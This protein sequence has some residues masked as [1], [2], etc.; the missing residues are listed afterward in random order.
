[1]QK[2]LPLRP[3]A[4]VLRLLPALLLLLSLPAVLSSQEKG[5]QK[6]ERQDY[7]KKWLAEDVTL[8]ISPE[9]RSVFEHLSEPEEKERFIEQFWLRRDTNPGTTH[10]EFKEEHYRRIAFANERFR[11]G[12]F[13]GWKTDRGRAYIRFGP[14][15]A[16]ESHPHGGTYMRPRNEG[17]GSTWAFPFEIWRYRHLEGIGSDLEIEFVD[18]SMSG[19]Y[20]MALRTDEKDALMNAPR[21]GATLLEN[22]GLSHKGDRPY[23]T[24]GHSNSLE[25]LSKS[26]MRSKDLPFARM[27]QF[28]NLQRPP[29][30]KFTDLR[31]TVTTNLSYRDFPFQIRQDFLHLESSS[32]LTPVTIEISHSDLSFQERSG[33]MHAAINVYG[34]VTGLTGGLVAEFEDTL[35]K[36]YSQADFAGGAM[37]KSVY[38][39]MFLLKAGTYKLNLVLKDVHSGRLGTF[40]GG[41]PVPRHLENRLYPSSLILASHI[42]KVDPSSDELEQFVIGDAKVIPSVKRTFPSYERIGVYFQLYNVAIDQARMEPALTLIYRIST[43]EGKVLKEIRDETGESVQFFSPERLVVIKTLSLKELAGGDYRLAVEVTDKVSGQTTSCQETFSVT[44][45]D[46]EG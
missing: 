13:P 35:N 32:F 41:L 31:S 2:G 3:W 8:I 16:K 14:P 23:F 17:S 22:L 24:P 33:M 42:W 38:Q 25:W 11:Y 9:E 28:F 26:G 44:A 46:R 5:V 30:I 7:F 43:L 27:E 45:D 19:E 36:D 18:R 1:M 6:E 15:D 4:R 20:R 29:Q 39:K 10:N 21:L 40:Q 37:R 12:G 34:A